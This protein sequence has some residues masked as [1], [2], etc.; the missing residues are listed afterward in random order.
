MNLYIYYLILT[1]NVF[2]ESSSDD[3]TS[4]IVAGKLATTSLSNI[5]L[6]SLEST[7]IRSFYNFEFSGFTN[8]SQITN[9]IFIGKI[10]VE[11]NL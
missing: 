2:K 9:K 7:E 8:E 6:N 3:F 4:V 5:M 11:Q 1:K 10:S